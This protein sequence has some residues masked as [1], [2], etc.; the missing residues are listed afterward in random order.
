MLEDLVIFQ[1][2]YDFTLWFFPIVN[3]FPKQ[4][5]FVLGQRIE[6]EILEIVELV[7]VANGETEKGRTLKTASAKLDLLRMLIRLAKDLRFVSVKQYG[8]ASERLNE[9][10]RLLTGLM[11]RFGRE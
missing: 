7:A 3:K 8:L 9:V 2:L 1:K 4:Q 11:R 5:R 10:G 6:N